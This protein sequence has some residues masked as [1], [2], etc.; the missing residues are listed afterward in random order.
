MNAIEQAVEAI[1][2][3]YGDPKRVAADYMIDNAD[4]QAAMQDAEPGSGYHYALSLL[5]E[6]N[7][8]KPV[9]AKD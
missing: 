9:K 8:P 3:T 7:P 1:L 2:A 6:V 4:I 5:A